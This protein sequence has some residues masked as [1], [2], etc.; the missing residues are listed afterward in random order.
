MPADDRKPE[1]V[2][3][4]ECLQEYT[5]AHEDIWRRLIHINTSIQTLEIIASY[6]LAYLFAP[7]EAIFFTMLYWN[8]TYTCIVML[9]AL[10]DDPK[11][12]TI[13]RFKNNLVKSWLPDYEKESFN[14]KLKDFHFS[15]K[16]KN[17]KSRLPDI[18]NKVIAHRDPEVV[19][20]SLNIPGLKITDLRELYNETEALFSVCSFHTEYGTTLYV[21]GTIGGK[22]VQ[23]DIE[24]ILDLLVKNSYWLNQ[25]ERRAP[26][27]QQIKPYKLAE[28]IEELNKWRKKF[29]LPEA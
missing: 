4:P 22:P 25:P 28:G 3:K 29:G 13:F 11:G 26:F 27:W 21:P 14:S 8:F 18:R 12:F 9:H 20:G 23:K 19:N 17:L 10:L 6:P 2:L 15:D 1:Q 5:T 24:Y 7:T 16:F